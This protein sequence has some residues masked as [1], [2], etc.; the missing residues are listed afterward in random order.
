M[1]RPSVFLVGRRKENAPEEPCISKE[2]ME[3]CIRN[4][5]RFLRKRNQ[6]EQMERTLDTLSFEEKRA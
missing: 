1:D 2:K 6:E 3:E 4:A 5:K